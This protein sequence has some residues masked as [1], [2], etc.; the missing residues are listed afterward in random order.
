MTH[1]TYTFITKDG[2]RYSARGNNRIE[3]QFET[4]NPASGRV[5]AH[6]GMQYEGVMRQRLM[7]KGK[8]VDVAQY[9]ILRTDPR[10]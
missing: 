8:Y 1:T 6:C 2:H 4:D 3:A 9:A 7:N 5:M 10:P